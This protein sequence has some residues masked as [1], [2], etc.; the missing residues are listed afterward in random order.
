MRHTQPAKSRDY[1][2]T[3]VSC[4]LENRGQILLLKR[5]QA[6]KTNKGKWSTVSGRVEHRWTAA[7]TALEEIRAETGL[8][9]RSLGLIRRGRPIYVRP[10]GTH[11]TKVVPFLFRV[12]R[13]TI[14]LNQEHTAA[15]WVRP[16]EVATYDTVPRFADLLRRLDVL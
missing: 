2:Y 9:R 10:T 15:V 5:S 6:V 11:L 13:R 7:D 3:A 12:T 4:V 8:E 1:R 16:E 14:R